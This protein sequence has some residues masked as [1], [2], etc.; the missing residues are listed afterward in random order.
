MLSYSIPP[1]VYLRRAGS[2][3]VLWS[4]SPPN[5][6]RA[7]SSAGRL[8]VPDTSTQVGGSANASVYHRV[9]A[10]PPRRFLQEPE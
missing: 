7:A 5:I 6:V 3:A 4:S 10:G 9:A 8:L 2:G 1:P